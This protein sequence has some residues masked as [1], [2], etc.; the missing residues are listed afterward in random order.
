MACDFLV[1]DVGARG[2]FV[3]LKG[4]DIRHA[5]RQLETSILSLKHHLAR[6]ERILCFVVC[7]GNRLPAAELISRK[8][9]FRK[10]LNADI[11]IRTKVGDHEIL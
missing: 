9:Y 1:I 11:I 3:E 10:R 4:G 5:L 7:S 6:N 2:Y 8:E